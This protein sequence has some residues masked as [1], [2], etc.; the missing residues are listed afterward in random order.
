MSAKLEQIRIV[1]LAEA[2]PGDAEIAGWHRVRA[3]AAAEAGSDAPDRDLAATAA[4]L[5]DPRPSEPVVR[6]LAW[7]GDTAVGLAW[8]R[9]HQ[10]EGR[11]HVANFR[12]A[13]PDGRHGEGIAEALLDEVRAVALAD[14]RSRLLAGVAVDSAGEGF[15]VD[16]G[17]TLGADFQRMRLRV[18]DC[19]REGLRATVKAAS[20]GYSLVR[21]QGVPPGDLIGPFAVTREAMNDMPVNTLDLGRI[22]WD[23]DRV[24]ANVRDAATRGRTLLTV[25]ALGLD[26]GGAEV[27]AGFSEIVL[28]GGGSSGARQSDTVVLREHRGRGLGLWVKA[29]MLEWLI[30]AH[31]EIEE[32]VTECLVTNTHMI[33]INEQ[34]GFRSVQGERYYQLGL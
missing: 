16:A 3:A 13:L 1:R 5:R 28:E 2:D 22:S 15:L 30:G 14:G 21:W 11:R 8:V 26:E 27:V 20:E 12:I 7:D 17:F 24:R 19:D 31:P 33:A 6:W 9:L 4:V 29:A 18:A 32:V 23:E 34:L 10:A 25:A